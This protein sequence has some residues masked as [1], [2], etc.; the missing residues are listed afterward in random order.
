MRKLGN[1]LYVTNPSSYLSRDGESVVVSV[2]N[3]D[4]GR[5][6]IRNL[7]GIVC[8]GFLGASPQLMELCCT[9]DVGLSFVSP[10][11]KYLAHVGGKVSGNVLLRKKQYGI[12]D[13]E[14]ESARV[15]ASLLA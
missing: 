1:T 12:S 6:P 9:F 11:G 5:V 3:Q 10:Y 13:D 7:D 8:F 15:A 4:V 2:E 14:D